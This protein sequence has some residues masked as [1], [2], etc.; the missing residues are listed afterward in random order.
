M[1]AWRS[2]LPQEGRAAGCAAPAAVPP[3]RRPLPGAQLSEPVAPQPPSRGEEPAVLGLEAHTLLGLGAVLLLMPPPL[4][5]RAAATPTAAM[6]FPSYHPVVAMVAPT[7][8][9]TPTPT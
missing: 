1:G 2:L 3:A 6:V 7:P 5:H 9:P 8:T 4:P